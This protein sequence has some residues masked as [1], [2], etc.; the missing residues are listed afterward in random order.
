MDDLS[1]SLKEIAN[2]LH[3]WSKH[4]DKV[5]DFYET[6]MAQKASTK[7]SN[8]KKTFKSEDVQKAP[9]KIAPAKKI[10]KKPV[11]AVSKQVKPIVSKRTTFIKTK[12]QTDA[13]KILTIFNRNKRGLT[14]ND[15]MKKS[16][17]NKK[18]VQNIIFKLKEEGMIKVPQRGVYSL[19]GK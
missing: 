15:L 3:V 13:Q 7:G 9:F 11:V 12:K 2:R 19:S 1:K 16:G 10:Q 18:K 4:I 8:Y 5:A 6:M 17:F 14:T